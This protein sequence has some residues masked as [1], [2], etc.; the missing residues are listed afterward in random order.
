VGNNPIIGGNRPL[1]TLA[2]EGL[3]VGKNKKRVR[4]LFLLGSGM[5]KHHSMVI[6]EIAG[7][8]GDG[9]NGK[10]GGIKED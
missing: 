6:W 10:R 5:Y 1:K 8:M 2:A 3:L 7:G 9:A 4:S